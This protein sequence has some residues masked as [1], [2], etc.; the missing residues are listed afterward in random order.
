MYTHKHISLYIHIYIY[1]YIIGK[2]PGGQDRGSPLSRDQ[3][4]EPPRTSL[5]V[6][7][8]NSLLLSYTY[9]EGQLSEPCTNN[10][11]YTY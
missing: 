7:Y 10:N 8:T 11:V 9:I 2:R 4:S 1:M 3:L 6:K 5:I